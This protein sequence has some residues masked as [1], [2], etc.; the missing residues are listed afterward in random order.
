MTLTKFNL[1]VYFVLL[2]R[3]NYLISGYQ[4][5]WIST[6]WCQN[7]TN[8]YH[9]FNTLWFILLRAHYSWIYIFITPVKIDSD[10]PA[11]FPGGRL[12]WNM[13]S[14]S[15]LYS[16]NWLEHCCTIDFLKSQTMFICV[17]NSIRK[18][19]QVKQFAKPTWSDRGR[20]ND[21]NGSYSWFLS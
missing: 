21:T 17:C 15:R 19:L 6:G 16:L 7:R 1:H 20:M 10:M 12:G 8:Y 13:N 5:R 2:Y 4:W 11:Y 14:L 9:F 3:N 18:R